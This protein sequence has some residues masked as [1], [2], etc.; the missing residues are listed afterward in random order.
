MFLYFQI[1]FLENSG[2]T[3]TL[4]KNHFLPLKQL[5][6]TVKGKLPASI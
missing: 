3:S 2:V 5:I 6:G 1:K 4:Q